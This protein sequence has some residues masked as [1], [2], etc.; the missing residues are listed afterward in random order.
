[1]E[2]PNCKIELEKIEGVVQHA[3]PTSDEVWGEWLECPKCGYEADIER[4][5]IDL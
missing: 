5:E 3:T 1:M 2:C 4:E